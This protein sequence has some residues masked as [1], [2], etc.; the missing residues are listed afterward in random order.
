[1][2]RRQLCRAGQTAFLLLLTLPAL[3]QQIAVP[4]PSF[5]EGTDRPAGWKCEGTGQWLDSGAAT[6]KHAIAATGNGKGSS[7]WVS[8]KIAFEPS[9]LYLLR[10]KARSI[11]ATSGTAISGPPFAN[12]DLGHLDKEWKS[13]ETPF[14]TPDQ[15]QPGES[16]LR[17]GQW[18]VNGSVAFDDVELLRAVPVYEQADGL[19]LGT[20]ESIDGN[21]YTFE[22]PQWRLSS[23]VNRPLLSHRTGYNTNRWNLARDGYVIYRHQIGGRSQDK[24]TVQVGVCYHTKGALTVEASTDQKTWQTLG[25]IDKVKVETFAIPV[26]L[27]PARSLFV[28]LRVADGYLQVDHYLYRC[29]IDGA[30]VRAIG[31]TT[32]IAVRSVD[33]RFTVTPTGIAGKVVSGRSSNIV[34]VATNPGEK[35]VVAV[36]TRILGSNE[37]ARETRL[38]LTHGESAHCPWFIVPSPGAYTVRLEIGGFVAELAVNVAELHE[39]RFGARLPQ[40]SDKLALWWAPS[41]WKISRERPAP[42][43]ESDGI[44]ISAAKNETEAAQFVLRPEAS[45]RNLAIRPGDLAGPEGASIPASAIEVLREQYVYTARPTDGTGTVD[46][47]PD[48]LPP[49]TGPLTLEPSINHAFWLRVHVPRNARAG[50]YNGTIQLT[51]DGVSVAMP[52][53]VE[54]YDFALPDR[55]TCTTAFGFSPDNV[56][57]YQKIDKDADKR[58]VLDKYLASFAAHHISPYNPA[59]LDP[60]KVT[61]PDK[62]NPLPVFDFTAWDAAMER[63]LARYHFNSF[64]VDIPGMGGGTFHER[65]EPELHG[66]KESTPEYKAAFTA[67]CRTLQEH[68]RQK[69]WLS[70]AFVYWFDEPDRKDYEFVANGFRRLKEAAPDLNRMLTVQVEPELIGGPNIWCPV[71]PNYNHDRAEPR[72][73]AGEKFWWYVCTGP[74]APFTT[75]FLDHPSV[76]LRVWLWQTWQRNID[77]ILVWETSYWTSSTAYPE[78]DQLQN[79]YEDPMSWQSGYGAP[80]GARQPWGNGDGRFIYPP[81]A[82]AGAAPA[83]PVLD[84]PVDSIRW[85]MLRDG[86]EDYEYLVI[87][88]KLLAEKGSKLPEAQRAEAEELLKVPA[89]ITTDMTHFNRSPE[90]I[91]RQRER[92]ARAIERLAH[93]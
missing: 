18:E 75:L 72:R 17:F 43:Q 2:L 20:G 36:A 12:R 16:F 60:I 74:K 19:E 8:D 89:E 28:R 6:G 51:A 61:W 30:P 57:R 38:T 26:S 48:P 59:P 58:A 76:E 42:T 84:G 54:V 73:Q 25:T 91:D 21:Q 83:V 15:I 46:H 10:F 34:F 87:L 33:A 37:P 45:T 39:T 90:P 29:Q 4:N 82:A 68:L 50:V 35:L 40:S 14:F 67:Y 24:A 23:N 66:F 53:R 71:T 5:E 27:L 49:I 93:L 63:N 77:G 3:A 69:G 11:D 13:F 41:G 79:P 44:R 1:M 47:W 81:Q 32:L 64:M 86:I 22:S 88:R 70:D 9:S 52:L 80:R 56:F 78:K 31:N 62:K 65:Y 55:M 7:V 85:E 92:V